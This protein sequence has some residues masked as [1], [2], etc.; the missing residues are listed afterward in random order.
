MTATPE[1]AIYAAYGQYYSQPTMLM[2]PAPGGAG[3][4]GA[5]LPYPP[6][7]PSA[8]TTTALGPSS[9]SSSSH[10]MYYPHT[11]PV[12]RTYALTPS[13]SS[14]VG[15][16]TPGM[17]LPPLQESPIRPK[18]APGTSRKGRKASAAAT[19]A[20]QQHQQHQQY[21]HHQ[22][23]ATMTLPPIP[24]HVVSHRRSSSSPSMASTSTAG[25]S[26]SLAAAATNVATRKR[27]RTLDIKQTANEGRRLV[28]PNP[29]EE[30]DDGDE[31]EQAAAFSAATTSTALP[32]P[33]PT[34]P[35][36]QIRSALAPRVVQMPAIT[37]T[38]RGTASIGM[39][40]VLRSDLVWLQGGRSGS[41]TSSGSRS[42]DFAGGGGVV[43]ASRR[44]P[45][46]ACSDSSDE[47]EVDVFG[48]RSSASAAGLITRSADRLTRSERKRKRLD[49]FRAAAGG[50]FAAATTTSPSAVGGG[51][52][53][54]ST[55]MTHLKGYGR[56]AC[57][58]ATALRFL[59]EVDDDRVV[60]AEE[61]NI[62]PIGLF[63]SPTTSAPGWPDEHFPWAGNDKTR[64]HAQ[65]KV[66]AV[67]QLEKLDHIGKFL[68]SVSDD[69][70]G[71]R[72]ERRVESATASDARDAL[73]AIE[74]D[75]LPVFAA[76]Q[77]RVPTMLDAM[78]GQ[79]IAETGCLCGGTASAGGE[80]VCCEKCSTWYHLACCGITNGD[81]L[82]EKWLCWRC[83]PK[84]TSNIRD[85]PV[86]SA[87]HTPRMR[88]SAAAVSSSASQTFA[89]TGETTRSYHA[90]SSDA[91]LAPSPVFSPSGKMASLLD[92]PAPLYNTPRVPSTSSF[93]KTPGTPSAL[94]NKAQQQQR[95]TS[96]AEHYNV[97]QTPGGAS[98]GE[99]QKI[100]STPKFE[101][102]YGATPNAAGG[103]GGGNP[104]SPTP[105]RR[106]R[107][108]SSGTG[109][110]NPLFTT[111]TSS[112]NFFRTLHSGATSASTPDLDHMSSA[113]ASYS[114]YPVSPGPPAASAY[115]PRLNP[116]AMGDLSTPSPLRGHKRQVSFGRVAFASASSSLRESMSIDDNKPRMKLDGPIGEEI[117]PKRQVNDRRLSEDEDILPAPNFD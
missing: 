6:P 72:G 15:Y 110:R 10:G 1:Q 105:S 40:D 93:F 55:T 68:D 83:E 87:L 53:A 66:A 12:Q 78:A 117:T 111:P 103:G 74:K 63:A 19:A 18:K 57:G 97:C 11:A 102:F 51:G 113:G 94:F 100:Y 49:A 23:S 92:T 106:A 32:P 17:P 52:E 2:T 14:S 116:A 31:D 45:A 80:M 96:Y 115:P 98:D 8:A 24:E 16:Y 48:T 38:P 54:S 64:R 50:G 28:F 86:P 37:T 47:G 25:T 13:S 20:E 67:V 43:G 91:P 88:H 107:V 5:T 29:S 27:T 59:G 4:G 108:F 22:H 61:E 76:G 90:H 75:G 101:D 26:T 73:L 85:S 69:D 33:P 81:E 39:K 35:P 44:L 21:H 42:D 95:I 104:S 62:K 60:E 56:M 65:D 112:Q 7:Y 71:E 99:Y 82:E 58:R 30:D 79:S 84:N 114:P 77:I 89:N 109:G 41:V 34:T 3:G 9:S 36:R 70:E 46:A